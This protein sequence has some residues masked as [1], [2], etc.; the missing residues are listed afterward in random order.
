MLN[1]KILL[2]CPIPP[3]Y[4][5][6]E[7]ATELLLKNI[8]KDELNYIFLKSNI[9][10]LN[11]KKGKFDFEGIYKFLFKYLNF[12]FI[13]IFRNPEKVYL[14][15][16][17]GRI[18]F[19]RDSIL[20]LT[21]KILGK[22][23]I[24]HY[25]GGNFNN[26]Y[27]KQ[28]KLFRKYILKV[29]K[30]I[31]GCIVQAEILKNIFNGLY[32][33]EKIKVLYNGIKSSGLALGPPKIFKDKKSFNLLYV[34]H[35]SF[36]KGFFY[37]IKA[38]KEIFKKYNLSLY[39]AG[40][41]RFKNERSDTQKEFLS[42][43]AL[44]FYKNNKDSITKTIDEFVE[45]TEKYNAKYLGIIHNNEKINAFNSSDLFILPSFTEG[46]SYSV[47]EAM[48]FG[49]PVIVTKVGALPEII[50]DEVNGFLIEEP[51]DELISKSIVK[52]ISDLQKL[53]EIS[54][55][56]KKYVD[57]NFSI[58]IIAKQFMEILNNN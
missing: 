54:L 10:K 13:L 8:A 47:L 30:K 25:R 3:P 42:G 44:E 41:L 33:M 57:E 14:L 48:T 39:F 45:N 34:G 22:I 31:D 5:G 23:I 20:I 53:E 38:Y 46:F 58:D 9:R 15:L 27:L 49:L 6:P 21:S 43:N 32:P 7:V 36:S 4:A 40:S 2:Y 52:A 51:D 24:V 29:L 19:L 18:G 50:K 28:N 11:W 1:N 17:S 35:I 56:N 55:N 12:V 26:F 16:S 37:L